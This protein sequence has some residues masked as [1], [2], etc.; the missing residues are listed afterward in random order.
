MFNRI[1]AL[2]MSVLLLVSQLGAL[3]HYIEH[4][5][6]KGVA[7]TQADVVARQA[8]DAD[9]IDTISQLCKLHT[10]AAQLAFALDAGRF[11]LLPLRAAQDFVHIVSD[12]LYDPA[13]TTFF[14]ARAPPAVRQP[15]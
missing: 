15:A 8:A 1:V 6:I 11:R 3:V 10:T 4:W 5:T 13:N 12:D 14:D 2:V 7:S 9:D